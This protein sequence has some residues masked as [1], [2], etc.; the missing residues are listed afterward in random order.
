MAHSSDFDE[1]ARYKTQLHDLLADRHFDS[2]MLLG[3]DSM[4]RT[5]FQARIFADLNDYY[6]NIEQDKNDLPNNQLELQF[7][8]GS[9]LDLIWREFHYPI[10]KLFQK[11][12]EDLY[13]SVN[14]NFSRCVNEGQPGKF[15]VKPVEL[16][17][18]HDQLQKFTKQLFNFYI[19]LL[20]YFTTHYDIPLLPRKF[21]EHFNFQPNP[22]AIR[23]SNTNFQANVLFLCHKCLVILGDI[24]RHK[25]K[26]ENSFVV[27]CLSNKAFFNNRELNT[28]QKS[29]LEEPTYEKAIQFYKLCIVLIPAL[30]EPYNHIGMICNTLNKQF[31]ACI[32]FLRSTLTRIGNFQVGMNNFK[33]IIR[34]KPFVAKLNRINSDRFDGGRSKT[35]PTMED[36]LN[37][38]LACRVLYL[39]DP[40][41]HQVDY[42]TIKK[43]TFSKLEDTLSRHLKSSFSKLLSEGKDGSNFFLNQLVFLISI[44]YLSEKRASEPGADDHITLNLDRFTYRYIDQFCT[45]LLDVELNEISATNSLQCFRLILNWIKE[46]KRAY[47]SLQ[48]KHRTMSKIV[49]VLNKFLEDNSLNIPDKV[50][51]EYA[52]SRSSIGQLI[53]L[54][55]RPLRSHYFQEDLMFKD[56]IVIRNQFRDFKDDLLFGASNIDALHGDYS[57]Y[58]NELGIPKFLPETVIARLTK[59]ESKLDL[60]NAVQVE[61]NRYENLARIQSVVLLSYK[62]VQEPLG[63][64]YSQSK[65]EITKGVVLEE[66]NPERRQMKRKQPKQEKTGKTLLKRLEKETKE[67]TVEVG[68]KESMLEEV[69]T[70]APISSESESDQHSADAKVSSSEGNLDLLYKNAPKS[71]EEIESFINNHT[72]RLQ[73]MTVSDVNSNGD[74]SNTDTE[75]EPKSRIESPSTETPIAGKLNVNEAEKSSPLVASI[76]RKGNPQ[77]D[78]SVDHFKVPDFLSPSSGSKSS[79]TPTSNQ[80]PPMP[81][82]GVPPMPPHQGA[83]MGAPHHGFYNG[84]GYPPPMPY[85]GPYNGQYPNPNPDQQYGPLINPGYAPQQV[86]FH[87]QAQPQSQPQLGFPQHFAQYYQQ[88]QQYYPPVFPNNTTGNQ[89]P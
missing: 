63:A 3:F 69:K 20:N 33:S 83:Y 9:Y 46:N 29:L 44:Y 19:S 67:K 58:C 77:G 60:T 21:T 15:K 62:L 80:V 49:Q 27:P 25:S 34:K 13:K 71:L 66:P 8:T 78:S 79:F 81:M 48:D 86:P 32:W 23:T 30:N 70:E 57:C 41:E 4:I 31:E 14:A 89:R 84:P 72:S 12:H 2:S 36:D 39:Y 28:I 76:W 11:L 5:K 51:T 65:I 7:N 18:L 52:Q 68:S 42:K 82:P 35:E 87:Q 74:I 16:R 73:E 43:T 53:F 47:R 55:T 85:Q 59:I 54:N 56:F 75:T 26:I 24:S 64:K 61:V 88:P 38:M 45:H 50:W 37:T 10:L 40:E 1:F 17:K 22:K 6:S